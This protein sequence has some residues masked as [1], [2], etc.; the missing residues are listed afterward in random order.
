MNAIEEIR[1]SSPP[2][3][4]SA[5]KRGLLEKRLKGAFK[6]GVKTNLIPK[7]PRH[8]GVA[9]SFAQQRLWFLDQIESNSPPDN[10]LQANPINY[11]VNLT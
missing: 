5:A 3:D 2:A 7:L 9:L 6:G 1:L 11:T 10:L 4:L 8:D